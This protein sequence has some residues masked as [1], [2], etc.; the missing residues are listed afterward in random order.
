MSERKFTFQ[1]NYAEML[2]ASW[3]TVR[4][5]WMWK[6]V[7]R[8]IALVAILM[9]AIIEFGVDEHSI[10]SFVT[11]ALVGIAIAAGCLFVTSLYWL[12][13]VPRSVR[14][15]YAQLMLDGESVEFSFDDTE[16]KIADSTST[17]ALAWNRW[18]KWTENERFIL[19]YR[20]STYAH[21][22][23]KSQVNREKIDA[24]RSQLDG[25][26]VKKV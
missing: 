24:L 8:Y 18:I 3:F 2:A 17:L 6:G 13:C 19:L 25:A 4:K 9:T 20:T 14:K 11:S 22:V 1:Y 5:R 16:L 21:F 7:I 10:F 12:W 15:A 26:G 23:P